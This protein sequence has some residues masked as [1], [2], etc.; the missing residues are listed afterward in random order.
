MSTRPRQDAKTPRRARRAGLAT[1]AVALV[2]L[3]GAM[4]TAGARDAY[5]ATRV[6]QSTGLAWLTS[7]AVGSL[8]LVDG[9]AGQP[10]ID[11]QV[12][13]TEG[14]ELDGGQ[15][16]ATGYALDQTTGLLTRVDGSTYATTSTVQPAAGIDA[17]TAGAAPQLLVGTR[18]GYVVDAADST[19]TAYDLSTL[20]RVGTPVTLTQG[21]ST[22]TAVVDAA[23]HLWVL[24]EDTGVLDRVDG[25]TA[26]RSALTFSHGK[27]GRAAAT[28]VAAGGR[29]VVL[30]PAARSAS[31]IMPDGTLAARLT[32]PALTAGTSGSTTY[33]GID[34]T[35][36]ADAGSVGNAGAAQPSLLVT[37]SAAGTYETCALVS[38]TC[39]AP[40]HAGFDA[41]VLGPA[42]GA[43]GRVFV[44]DYTTGSTWVLDPGGT[45]PPVRTGPLTAPGQAALELSEHGGLVFYN[46]PGSAQ[47]GTLGPDG[48][49][50]PVVK[51]GASGTAA[52]APTSVGTAAAAPT[53]AATTAAASTSAGAPAATR[54]PTTAAPS[55][56]AAK[57]TASA[58]GTTGS[59]VPVPVPSVT[60]G[61]VSYC[62]STTPAAQAASLVQPPSEQGGILLSENEK[63]VAEKAMTGKGHAR[64]NL[65][66]PIAFIGL[67]TAALGLLTAVITIWP[68]VF[69]TSDGTPAS[70]ASASAS[71]GAAPAIA[72]S[73]AGAYASLAYGTSMPQK[74]KFTL[75]DPGGTGVY[76]LAFLS[77]SMIATGDM[78]GDAYLFDLADNQ[79]TKVLTGT[80]DMALWGLAYD[81]QRNLLAGG[82]SDTADS[83]RT[84]DVILWNTSTGTHVKTLTTPSDTGIGVGIAFS[85]DGGTFAYAADDTNEI[86]RVDT[87]TFQQIGSPFR[88]P[89]SYG[90]YQ[91][92]YSPKTGY[93]ATADGNGTAYLWDTQGSTP[94]IVETFPD[95]DPHNQGLHSVTFSPDGSIL[96]L[97]DNNGDIYLY[98][99]QRDAV[100]ATIHGLKGARVSSIDFSP[101]KPVLAAIL[102]YDDDTTD[103]HTHGFC[104]WT[105]AGTELDGRQDPGTTG[106]TTLAF[107]PDGDTLAVGDANNFTYYWDVSSVS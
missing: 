89:N 67:V 72:G 9:V 61:T 2:A 41:D 1:T 37:D 103:V 100:I 44:P 54:T 74:P 45:A 5:P 19:V 104:L 99:V 73:T 34:D 62:M 59:P 31:L 77:N 35:D 65:D 46:D 38:G 51:Y 48:T 95:P 93:L 8:T 69:H 85:P 52:A 7:D 79:T 70:S 14:D 63:S 29:P 24:D 17:A 30:D 13:Q 84:G 18:T 86:Y 42:L 64:L 33:S 87:T 76:S 11:V 6:D 3:V 10:V 78:N 56:S 49:V 80:P 40:S 106:G 47:A 43:D 58:A 21:P 25:A 32:L 36:A 15:Q 68:D 20:R 107:S 4:I 82:T 16:G 71:A 57:P 26:R 27:V 97:G 94:T 12:V 53:S 75:E 101:D 90:V 50:R 39:I 105:T 92:A 98:N 91:M 83:Y 23:D 22:L 66:N 81:P 60:G 96:A 55:R 102:D 28:L 88:D